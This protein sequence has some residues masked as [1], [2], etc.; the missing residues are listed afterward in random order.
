MKSIGF[1]IALSVVIGLSGVGTAA[2]GPDGAAFSADMVRQGGGGQDSTGKMFVSGGRVRT[3]MEQGGRPVVRISDRERRVEWI[4]FP[5]QHSYMERAGAPGG[6]GQSAAGADGTEKDPCAGIPGLVCRAI[7]QQDISGR[8]A[9][10]WEMTSTAQGQ[11]LKGE[12]W[13]DQER[14]VPL[15]QVMPN[16]QAMELTLVGNETLNGRA[17]EKWEMAVTAPGGES[18]R[19]FQW[20]DPELALAIRE[21]FPGGVVSEMKNIRVG[22][23]PDS[24]FTVPAGYQRITMPGG[25]GQSST[26]AP[27]L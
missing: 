9:V 25:V 4:L 7:G 10:G 15:R 14:G 17:V 2:A 5:D 8:P 24:L 26:A 1:C 13:I 11:T 12:Q 23:Q 6:E 18:V 22:E 21:E 27:K 16:G 20:Y 3:E 19:S